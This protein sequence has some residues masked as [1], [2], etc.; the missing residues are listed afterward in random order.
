MAFGATITITVNAVAKVLNRINQDN[1]GSEYKLVTSTDLWKLLIRHSTDSPDSEGFTMLRHNMYLEH[2]T[3]ATAVL[4]AY[5][6]SVTFTMRAGALDG[7]VQLALDAKGVLAY[8]SASSYLVVD[9]L[10]VGLN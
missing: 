5:K 7:N 1:Y 8:L 10:V 9:D 6:E 3:Y 4:P 2:T